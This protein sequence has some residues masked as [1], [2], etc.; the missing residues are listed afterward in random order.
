MINRGHC[1]QA[2]RPVL[3]GWTPNRK[4][5]APLNLPVPGGAAPEQGTE[6]QGASRGPKAPAVGEGPGLAR[7]LPGASAFNP[8]SQLILGLAGLPY[9]LKCGLALRAR[10]WYQTPMS[11]VKWEGFVVR[12]NLI[13][14]ALLALALAGGVVALSIV[15]PQEEVILAECPPSC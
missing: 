1:M 2:R 3:R 13:V 7:P 8:N 11:V 5:S 10:I 4:N 14:F 6:Y 9:A 15:M 12:R